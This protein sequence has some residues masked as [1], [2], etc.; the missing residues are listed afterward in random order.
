[1]SPQAHPDR[2]SDWL[3]QIQAM[4]PKEIALGLQR[5]RGAY[6][7]M[8]LRF[9]APVVTFAG[10]NG[11][12]ST[13]G[14]LEQAAVHQNLKVATYTSPHLLDFNERVR[15]KGVPVDDALFCKAFEAVETARESIPLTYFEFTTLAAFIIIHW[16]APDLIL[17]EI[18]LGGRLDAVNLVDPDIA[19]ITSI[20]FDHQD[21][22]GETLEEIAREKAGVLRQGKPLVCGL[23]GD[24]PA[25]LRGEI[26][27]LRCPYYGAPAL[28]SL[29]IDEQTWTVRGGLYEESVED[30][31][32]ENTWSL[33]ALPQPN[34]CLS[35][36]MVAL[37]VW[38]LLAHS[39]ECSRP[40]LASMRWSEEDIHQVLRHFQVPGRWQKLDLSL[41]I[42]LDVA[43]NVQAAEH[44]KNN[45]EKTRQA[46][47]ATRVISIFSAMSDKDLSGIIQ[48]VAPCVD[49]WIPMALDVERA[50]SIDQ[51]KFILEALHLEMAAPITNF[52]AQWAERRTHFNEEKDLLVFWGSFYVLSHIL[53]SLGV[54]PVFAPKS[55]AR[56][57]R[58]GNGQGY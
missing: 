33:E 50:A 35:N 54:S 49:V 53:P 25:S 46:L 36:A 41:N 44:L 13:L 37:Q 56:N 58:T 8:K 9:E 21:W 17:L 16:S 7:R 2:L 47:G 29:P 48:A 3:L 12:G 32:A 30:E 19:V 1:M 27:R 20:A 5:I 51:I 22:L 15:I 42:F 18:G 55:H 4:H 14:L 38:H 52:D 34:I 57:T 39:P 43:H 23:Q 11:K 31:K 24:L 40:G 10:T 28:N 45:I 6:S 26:E